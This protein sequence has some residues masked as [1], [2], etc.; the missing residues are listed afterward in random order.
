M[1]VRLLNKETA[2]NVIYETFGDDFEWVD[3][4]DGI[5]RIKIKGTE[6]GIMKWAPYIK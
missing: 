6:Y 3:K 1:V 2:Y 4:G 5:D